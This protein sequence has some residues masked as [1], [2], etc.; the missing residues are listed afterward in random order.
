M[1][2]RWILGK[3]VLA[4][5]R[6][7]SFF[8]FIS[9]GIWLQAR[10]PEVVKHLLDHVSFL[11]DL[12]RSKTLH[13]GDKARVLD[14]VR[15]QF[16]QIASDGVELQIGFPHEP[17][18][19]IVGG[20]SNAVSVPLELF[21]QGH[22]RLHVATATN[23]LDDNVELG[24]PRLCYVLIKPM[25]LFQALDRLGFSIHGDSWVKL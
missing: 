24:G 13:A 5:V 9:Q 8:N 1:L 18:K 3:G 14:H 21:A 10:L 2:S 4:T 22:E 11:L 15:H 12:T 16:V 23:D 25:L 6:L 17:G 7:G 19:H 20:D